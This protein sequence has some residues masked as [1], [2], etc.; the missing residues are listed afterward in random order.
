MGDTLSTVP[1]DAY[2][3]FKQIR[4]SQTAPY[5]LQYAFRFYGF[6][7][8][9]LA[10]VWEGMAQR[11]STISV[12]VGAAYEIRRVRGVVSYY[13]NGAKV[14]ESTRPSFGALIVN[15]CLYTARDSLP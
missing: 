14:Y 9:A 12:P 11:T 5:R 10:E 2:V 3:G 15:A 4:G 8:S 6:G 13:L 7:N 1:S